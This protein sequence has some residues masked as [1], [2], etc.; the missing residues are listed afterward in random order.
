[1]STA[2]H[3]RALSLV[4]QNRWLGYLIGLGLISLGMT[5]LPS[6]FVVLLW[7]PLCGLLAF[8]VLLLGGSF[9]A[10]PPDP[11]QIFEPDHPAHG[12][13]R[14]VQIPDGDDSIPGY[15]LKPPKSI[16]SEAAVCLVHGAGDT[17]TSYKWLL[18]RALLAEGLTVLTI[19]LPGHGDYR[20]RL[21]TYPEVLTT[22]PA[23]LR[24]LR[25]QPGIRQVG[26]I[27]ISLGGAIAIR[28]LVE[29]LPH[30]SSVADALVVLETPIRLD[31]SKALFY[32][33]MW[34]TLYGA[35]VLWLLRE[36]SVK[37]AW[38][39]WHR[40]GYRSRYTTGRL[41]ELLDPQS[42]IGRLSPLPILLVY[43]R[44]DGVAPTEHAQAMRQAAPQATFIE[45]K[46]ASHVVLTLMPEINR[47][48]ASWLKKQLANNVF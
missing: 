40:G 16:G 47:Q 2:L 46:K 25:T 36:M 4:G 44:R 10:P 34:R 41:F 33:E 5:F 23:A 43:S 37:Q 22:V 30:G 3:L 29:A 24:F 21:L 42:C 45:T 31:Y 27:G 11:D 38:D 48:V 7:V 6:T 32:Q 18:V 1:M 28:S 35:P 20:H 17:K 39:T 14:Q 8:F 15:L 19:D 9:V 26:V 12:T 13:S